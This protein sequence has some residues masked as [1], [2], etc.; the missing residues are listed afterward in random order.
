MPVLKQAKNQKFVKSLQ[1]TITDYSYSLAKKDRKVKTLFL[2]LLK[3]VL[4]TSVETTF[5][6]P[7]IVSITNLLANVK[8]FFCALVLLPIYNKIAF[9]RAARKPNISARKTEN[10]LSLYIWIHKRFSNRLPAVYI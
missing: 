7:Y 9:Y 5:L 6:F 8:L 1:R 3:R 2:F 10:L 4:E